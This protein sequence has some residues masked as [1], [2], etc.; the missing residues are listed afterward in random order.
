MKVEEKFRRKFKRQPL[1]A[2]HSAMCILLSLAASLIFFYYTPSPTMPAPFNLLQ[3]YSI[4]LLIDIP[5]NETKLFFPTFSVASFVYA[6][7][8]KRNKTED[9]GFVSVCE[10]SVFS[11]AIDIAN[12]FFIEKRGS[13]HVPL[14]A[15]IAP[16]FSLWEINL[17]V[18]VWRNCQLFF[19]VVRNFCIIECRFRVSS[20]IF[21]FLVKCF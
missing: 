8:R 17:R 5:A 9:R 14:I 12:G 11:H 10:S 15:I 18:W 16:L 20:G 7:I 19:R 21:M 1:P 4:S 6:P 3:F 13:M 2:K